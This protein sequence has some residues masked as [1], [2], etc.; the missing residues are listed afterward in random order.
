M[1]LGIEQNGKGFIV[2]LS[3]PYTH[4]D[5]SRL[6]EYAGLITNALN[7]DAALSEAANRTV[8]R[9]IQGGKASPTGDEFPVVPV[10]ADDTR[11]ALQ[12]ILTAAENIEHGWN[13][14]NTRLYTDIIKR[15][16]ERISA[17]IRGTKK[18]KSGRTAKARKP[19]GGD[20]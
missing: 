13:G 12:A 16:V 2:L 7:R 20:R 14:S 17:T 19:R 3:D 9:I 10:W 5:D 6:Q 8:R 4:E 15:N 1:R 11:Q 18:G